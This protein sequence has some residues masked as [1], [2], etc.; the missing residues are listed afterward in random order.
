MRIKWVVTAAALIAVVGVVFWLRS[1]RP[2]V[3]SAKP[4]VQQVSSELAELRDEVSQLRSRLER[5]EGASERLTERIG[6]AAM[7]SSSA[8]PNS[9]PV[10]A[11]EELRRARAARPTLAQQIARFEAH[12]ANLDALRGDQ[13]DAP[14]EGKFRDLLTNSVASQLTA[15]PKAQIQ[16][17]SCGNEFCKVDLHFADLGDV[18]MGQTEMSLQ[19]SSMSKGTTIYTEPGTGRIHAYV[20][21]GQQR[22][23]DFP[24][25]E[26]VALGE[27]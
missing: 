20:A 11:E 12:F 10:D 6:S 25:V 5:S 16:E 13:R 21:T 23:P 24:T 15:L 22:L 27:R 8:A 1:E 17:I 3:A 9:A 2:K 18:R 26:E 19:L 4:R 7:A 14:L